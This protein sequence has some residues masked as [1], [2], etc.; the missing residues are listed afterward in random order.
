[1]LAAAGVPVAVAAPGVGA[2]YADHFCTRMNWRVTQPVT[3]N[4]Q[5]RGLPLAREVARYFL[6][7]RGILTLG[8]GL[9]HGFVRTRPGLEGPDAQFFFM[10]ASYANAAERR[11]DREPGMTLGVTQL[12]PESRGT[13]HIRSA[14]PFAQPS[15]R[16]NFL[17]AEEDRRCMV[18][19]MKIGRAVMAQ[20]PMDP[21]RGPE[22]S[23][24]A[25][26]ETDADWLAFARANGQTIYHV[27]GTCRMGGDPDAPLDARLRFRGIESLR[28]ADAAAMPTMVS[29][30]TQAAVFML[31]EKAADLIA[32][33][34]KGR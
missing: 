14:D 16:P 8:T 24:G 21:F 2:N 3:L 6:S 17:D 23:P 34:A 12:R 30:N 20:A 15:I 10:H 7:R 22:L 4:E 13:I 31:A 26:C 11:L 1:V 28:V 18:E 32:E 5:T 19:A 29:G 33:D 27:A 25:A 9:A